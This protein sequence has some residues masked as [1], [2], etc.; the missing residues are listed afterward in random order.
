MHVS[1]YGNTPD[2]ISQRYPEQIKLCLR[3][4][5]QDKN[6]DSYRKRQ[7]MSRFLRA[8]QFMIG[9]LYFVL[10]TPD[11]WMARNIFSYR[12]YELYDSVK[13]IILEGQKT[14]PKEPYGRIE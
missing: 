6:T 4:F 7:A 14:E 2:T 12:Q 10:R 8:R 3:Y 9:G 5:T 13:I 1:I 11:F